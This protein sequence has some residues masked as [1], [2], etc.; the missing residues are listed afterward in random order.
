MN[1]WELSDHE[2]EVI[3]EGRTTDDT[4]EMVGYDCATAAQ[5][6]LVEWMAKENEAAFFARTPDEWITKHDLYLTRP[7]WRELKAALGVKDA[8]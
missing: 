7:L 6:K 1:E 4:F 3:C 5:K 2:I 8:D